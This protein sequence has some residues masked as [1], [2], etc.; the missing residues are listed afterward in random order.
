MFEIFSGGVLGTLL[1]GLFRLAPEILKFFDKKNERQHELAM[2]QHQVDLEKTKGDIRLGEI[3]AQRQSDLDT[4]TLTALQ[5]AIGQQTEM[6]KYA[7]KWV[8]DLSASVRP[9]ITYFVLGIWAWMHFWFAWKTSVDAATAFKMM[10]TPDFVALV[11]GTIN[12]WFLDRTLTK[13]N[14]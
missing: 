3:N 10:M 5:L 11:S 1:G 13:R 9:V 12:Y 7:H 4:G 8:A 6:V 2:F 14:L